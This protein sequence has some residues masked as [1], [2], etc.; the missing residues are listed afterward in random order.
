MRT[1]KGYIGLKCWGRLHAH[2]QSVYWAEM[3]GPTAWANSKGILG[4]MVGATACAH[5]KGIM[6]WNGGGDCSGSAIEFVVGGIGSAGVLG[7]SRIGGCR[8]AL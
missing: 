7:K 2:T 5:S 6:G 3:L 1:L 8:L 4:W